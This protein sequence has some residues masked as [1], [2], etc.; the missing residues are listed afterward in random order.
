MLGRPTILFPLALLA[1]LAL[2]TLWIERSVQPPEKKLDGSTR[3]DPD[4][5]LNS[6]TTTRT[7]I[8]GN[9]KYVLSAEEMKHYPDD[10]TT[11]LRKPHFTQFSV[12]KPYTKVESDRGFVS[13]D[14]ENVQFLGNVKV[15]RQ[16]FKD[17][18]EMTV[19]T[20]FL[21]VVPDK[22]LATT[23]R[24]VTIHQAPDTVI[25]AVGMIY[26]KK[27][28]TVQLKSRVRAHYVKPPSPQASR[29]AAKP[30]KAASK[31]ASQPAARTTV[32]SKTQTG[33]TSKP[34]NNSTRI[35]R[36]Y[37]PASP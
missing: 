8:N 10:D 2:L 31:P 35:R 16:A 33:Q 21:D 1:L 25:H 22:E 37:E 5:I 34:A 7:D 11:E 32:K 4:Y 26:D 24:P 28:K 17:R 30:A 19:T 23:D 14:G 3:H 27:Q 6:F 15:V 12:E 29:A 9:L 20:D 18:G 36:T 13:S